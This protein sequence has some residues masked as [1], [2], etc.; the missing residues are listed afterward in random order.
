MDAERGAEL[1]GLQERDR[2][3]VVSLTGRPSLHVA[4][5]A[6]AFAFD[7]ARRN[8]R[9]R[10]AAGCADAFFRGRHFS[11]R[12][13]RAGI[14]PGSDGRWGRDWDVSPGTAGTAV[15]ACIES[16]FIARWRRAQATWYF[17]LR[18]RFTC[19]WL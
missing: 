18:R 14:S 12:F 11:S 13:A 4:A 8:N 16:L 15:R 2:V 10:N 9:C 17:L 6:C 5:C 3:L 7:G 19:R 1:A